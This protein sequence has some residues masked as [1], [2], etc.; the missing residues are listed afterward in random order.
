MRRFWNSSAVFFLA[1]LA[2]TCAP[3]KGIAQKISHSAT[4]TGVRERIVRAEAT[5]SDRDAIMHQ[6]LDLLNGA[7]KNDKKDKDKEETYYYLGI[8][9]YRMSDFDSAWNNLQKATSFGR[10]FVSKGEKLPGGIVLFAIQETLNDIKLKTFNQAN[11]AYTEAANSAI[12]DTIVT[13]MRKSIVLFDKILK[14][15]AKAII[16]EQSFAGNI[17]GLMANANVQIM[18]Y[19]TEESSRIEYRNEAI[20]HLIHFLEH[21]T[22]NLPVHQFVFQLYFQ[23]KDH[24]KCIEWI[25]RAL[26]ISKNDSA[27]QLIKNDLIS[28]KALLLDVMGKPDEALET[29]TAAIAANPDNADLHF[30]LARLYLNRKETEKALSEF[31]I[32]KKLKPEDS[33]SNYQV[34]DEVFRVYLRKRGEVIDKAGTTK[35]DMKKITEILKPDIE[36]AKQDVQDALLVMEKNASEMADPGEGYYRIGK[37]YNMV[38]ELEGHL[39]YNLDNKEKVKLQKPFFEKAAEY[40]KKSVLNSPDSKVAWHQL[41][42]AY[43]NLQMKKEAEDAFSK[44]K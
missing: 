31:K 25:N 8:I 7:V 5:P 30:N 9:Y 26:T 38:A 32:V 29:Y 22:A 6:A 16:N 40:L 27:S 23:S 44:A 2:L 4:I 3:Q 37:C 19:Q 36:A 10:R 15:D 1:M 24:G 42:T 43:M 13:L 12:P 18:N 17:H 28:Q 35:V 14:W 41:G 20:N 21:D 11:R 33:E 34:A 39:N